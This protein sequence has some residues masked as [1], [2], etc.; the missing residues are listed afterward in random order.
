MHPYPLFYPIN[1]G[2]FGS[3]MLS[4]GSV[5]ARHFGPYGT[6]PFSP[7]ALQFINSIAGPGF[8][9]GPQ[10]FPSPIPPPHVYQPH[11]YAFPPWTC[12]PQYGYGYWPR[13]PGHGYHSKPKIHHRKASKS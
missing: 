6:G 10:Q 13:H 5:L 8:I 2:Y 12:Q 7:A 3:P 11:H 1:N 9:P 4:P